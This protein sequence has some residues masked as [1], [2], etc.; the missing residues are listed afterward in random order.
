MFILTGV[1][2]VRRYFIFFC[3]L[4]VVLLAGCNPAKSHLGKFN[5]YFQQDSFSESN[6]A[7]STEFAESKIRKKN[8]GG[9]DLLWSMQVG[10]LERLRKDYQR[11]NEY[12][13]K[14][15]EMLGHFDYQ[16]QLADSA[17]AVASTENILPYTGA[18]YDGIMVNTYKALNF[19]ATGK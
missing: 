6:F 5:A 15:E 7:K 11:S 9:A 18:E 14:S 10:L 16:N 17:L 1:Y 4:G 12:F 13:D 3:L 19:M 8:P 2:L